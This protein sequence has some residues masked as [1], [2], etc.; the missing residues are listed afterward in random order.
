MVWDKDEVPLEW[1]R[2]KVM[3]MRNLGLMFIWRENM[4][5]E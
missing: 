1:S 4:G 2:G 5:L 3:G